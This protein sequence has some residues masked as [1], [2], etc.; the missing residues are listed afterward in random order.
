MSWFRR[1][2]EKREPPGKQ[3]PQAASPSQAGSPFTE[4]AALFVRL[5]GDMV[6][7]LQLDYSPESLERLD[8]FI[9]KTFEGPA[10]SPAPD[11]LQADVGAYVGEVVRRHV[12]GEWAEDGSVR[13]VGGE[14]SQ[15]NPIGKARKRFANGQEDSLAWFYATVVRHAG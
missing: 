7:A 2:D 8:Q 1:R 12:G 11:N 6:P 13:A 5:I 9:S 4:Q 14:V 3:Q 15:V 10:A